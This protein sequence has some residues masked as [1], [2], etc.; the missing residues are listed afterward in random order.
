MTHSET[1]LPVAPESGDWSEEIERE[2]SGWYELVSLVRSLSVEECLEPGYYKDPDWS[3]RDLVAHIGAWLAEAEVQLERMR[4][5]TY[6]GHD[7][8][9]DALNAQFLEATHDMPFDMAWSQANAART[10]MIQ[11][12]FA[13][14]NRDAESA[15]WVNKSGGEHY[16]EHLPR[17]QDWVDE[18]KARRV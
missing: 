9:V 2:R 7:V 1:G 11:D 18:L 12:W 5:G 10:L 6:S 8:D 15:W 14:P 3:V 13:L 16:G 17:L 4:G